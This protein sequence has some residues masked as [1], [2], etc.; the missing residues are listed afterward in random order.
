M[1]SEDHI[2]IERAF[3][4]LAP[5]ADQVQQMVLIRG[6]AKAL[7]HLIIENCPKSADRSTAIR[8]VR[9]AVMA[10]NAAIVLKGLF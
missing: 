1:K 6:A 10:A 5:D 7:A 3:E 9:E 8:R 2:A 4:H